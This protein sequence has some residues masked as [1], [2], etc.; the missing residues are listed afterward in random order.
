MSHRAAGSGIESTPPLSRGNDGRRRRCCAHERDFDREDAALPGNVADGD[1]AVLRAHGLACD[2][3]AE[4]EAGAVL[5]ATIAKGCERI[6]VRRRDAA[7]LI[8]NL[9]LEFAALRAGRSVTLPPS[10]VCLK[11]LVP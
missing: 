4:P 7:A 9:D 5:A 6:P 1:V 10:R 2:R 3:E 11:A 8:L